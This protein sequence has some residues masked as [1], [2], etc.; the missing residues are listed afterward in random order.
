VNYIC[1]EN[2]LYFQEEIGFPL[3]IKTRRLARAFRYKTNLP[4]FLRSL[5]T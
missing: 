1:I 4:L 3:C 5:K 2:A